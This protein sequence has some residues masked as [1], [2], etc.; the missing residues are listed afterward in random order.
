MSVRRVSAIAVW[1]AALLCGCRDES[2]VAAKEPAAVRAATITVDETAGERLRYSASIVPY[3][4]VDLAFRT[5]GYV[6]NIMQVRGA[7][8]RLRD[9]GSG[10]YAEQGITLAHIRREDVQNEVAKARAQL[11]E[12]AAQHT[13]AEL[14][15]QRAQ[16]LYA[17]QSLTKTEY[18]QSNEAFRSTQAQ[19]ENARAALRQAE[20]TLQDVDLKAPFPG[21]ILNRRIQLGTL[22]SP[23]TAAFTIAD[24]SRVKVTFG[25]P[26][27]VLPRVRLG[28][29]IK[30]KPENGGSPLKG[31]ITSIA[32]AAD[33]RD[34]TFAVEVSVENRE[35]SL[36]PG[37]I[38]SVNLGE[39]PQ[40]YTA[41][42]LSA[43]VTFGSEGEAFGVM[44][45]EEQAGA[46]IAK[47]RRIKVLAIY[48]NAVAVEGVQPGERVVSAGAPL[49]KD[50]DPVQL[51]P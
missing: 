32:T 20:L 41:I 3:A 27:Y 6:T 17:T 49:L 24:I 8:G 23:S 9:I 11:D 34:R 31:K 5:S 16:A 29:E 18:D 1:M 46:L 35:G 50:G 39:A 33:T 43:V 45:V 4:E 51:I 22:V 7:D 12:A 38:V 42:P 48:D 19:I 36:K 15:F 25:I 14:D 47:S 28:Q 2:K 37:M 44:V 26:D 30:I 21:Y 13:R 40:S 10:D